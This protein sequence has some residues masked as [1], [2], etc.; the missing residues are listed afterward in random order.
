MTKLLWLAWKVEM[1]LID[2]SPAKQELEGNLSVA[3]FAF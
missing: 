1:N 2:P 3:N